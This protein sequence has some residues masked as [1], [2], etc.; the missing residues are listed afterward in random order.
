MAF[1]NNCTELWAYTNNTNLLDELIDAR[2][3]EILS[4]VCLA[5]FLSWYMRSLSRSHRNWNTW[6]CRSFIDSWLWLSNGRNRVS[7]SSDIAESSDRSLSI[8]FPSVMFVS[9]SLCSCATQLYCNCVAKIC[10]V[11]GSLDKPW[12]SVGRFPSDL[13]VWT[14]FTIAA[15][16]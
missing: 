9:D 3:T 10:N 2:N 16:A 8:S 13:N 11:V 5:R 4:R 14:P 1:V 12:I 7:R 6:R 15:A